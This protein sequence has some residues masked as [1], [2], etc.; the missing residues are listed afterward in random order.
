MFK[1]HL[2]W[3]KTNEPPETYGTSFIVGDMLPRDS[4]YIH[5]SI[6]KSSKVYIDYVCRFEIP[7]R[8][9]NI[10]T[11]LFYNKNHTSPTT[12][13]Y[14]KFLCC[15]ATYV[16]TS[17]TDPSALQRL[18]AGRRT[19]MN[20]VLTDVKKVKCKDGCVLGPGQVNSGVTFHDPHSIKILVYRSE[21]V[22]KVMLHEMIHAFGL[23]FAFL[24]AQTIQVHE[25]SLMAHWGTKKLLKLNESFTDT[26][27]CLLNICLFSVMYSK[28][29]N[30]D[31]SMVLVA[32]FNLE[33]THILERCRIL[34]DHM[35]SMRTYEEA[36]H[37]I[38]Y[39]IY[40]AMNMCAIRSF[41]R[42]HYDARKGRIIADSFSSYCT[43]LEGYDISQC[44]SGVVRC[45]QNCTSM[46]MSMIDVMSFIKP[47]KD[48]LFKIM[49][50]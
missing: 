45:S 28:L 13:K 40:K 47:W 8:G 42:A 6:Y 25:A 10:S 15:L 48:K 24:D 30:R 41:L 16:V 4:P 7:M 35:K 50:G 39:Y 33:K 44:S 21:E 26:W 17:M 34:L 20:I 38:S 43:L 37:A 31:P 9:I 27:A 2:V 14:I 23:D 22:F 32:V 1:E 18:V 36:T 12:V 11:S 46:R 3:Y 29:A 5:E 49:M 19:S